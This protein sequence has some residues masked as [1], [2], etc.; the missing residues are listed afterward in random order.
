M[1]S[2]LS[3]LKPTPKSLALFAVLAFICVGGAIQS[4]AF[5]DDIPEVPKPPLYDL[6]KPLELWVPWIFLAAP[7][8]LLG[9]LLD[10][11]WLLDYFPRLGGVSAPVASVAYA[12]VISCWAA[13]SWDRWARHGRYGRLVPL[14]GVALASIFHFPL[15]LLLTIDPLGYA[16]FAI[17]GFA[18]LAAV[19]AVYAVSIY[20]LY[21]A[22]RSLL[23]S[24]P[25]DTGELEGRTR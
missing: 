1:A 18:F 11:W 25:V 21:R 6:L 9:S 24:R 7:V 5:I 20:G 2:P 22:G 16:A 8:H 23:P 12:Y 19:F 14:V 4:Y 17:S 15:V 13:Y 10:L 3:F